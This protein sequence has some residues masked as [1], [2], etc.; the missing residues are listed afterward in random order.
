VPFERVQFLFGFL[1][2][3]E[4]LI[5]LIFL[6]KNLGAYLPWVLIGYTVITGGSVVSELLGLAS[7]HLYI[8]LKDI[9]PNS[10]GYNFLRTPQFVYCFG[11][12]FIIKS[13]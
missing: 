13:F 12:S 8:I 5:I 11:I 2:T 4:I 9:V 1:V 7:G 6:S 10:H 3:S